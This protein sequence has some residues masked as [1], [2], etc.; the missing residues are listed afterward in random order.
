M[1]R[2]VITRGTKAAVYI[3]LHTCCLTALLK[4]D[5]SENLTASL[6]NDMK[7]MRL[8]HTRFM[9]FRSCCSLSEHTAVALM[10]SSTRLVTRYTSTTPGREKAQ[11]SLWTCFLALCAS[12]FCDAPFATQRSLK[13]NKAAGPCQFTQ[14][15]A[16]SHVLSPPSICPSEGGRPHI[17]F[18]NKRSH[19]KMMCERVCVCFETPHPAGTP[20]PEQ[21]GWP[22]CR[23]RSCWCRS[24]C[25]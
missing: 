21:T 11:K 18:F 16:I 20:C 22:R 5:F 1:Y 13:H 14:R 2:G 9:S 19:F 17:V 3:N 24:G 7:P 10:P 4:L 25:Y 12:L 23:Q 15:L 6:A 8:F